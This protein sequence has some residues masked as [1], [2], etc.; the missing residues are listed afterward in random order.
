MTENLT[1]KE[2]VAFRAAKETVA[3]TQAILALRTARNKTNVFAA[4][5]MAWM[6]QAL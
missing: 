6:E 5:G 3:R 2:R 4:R 1:S